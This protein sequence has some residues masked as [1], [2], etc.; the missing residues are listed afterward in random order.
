MELVKDF[1]AIVVSTKA[2]VIKCVNMRS[3]IVCNCV[4]SLMDDPLT[5]IKK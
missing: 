2:L 1:V 3:K 5:L 4:T